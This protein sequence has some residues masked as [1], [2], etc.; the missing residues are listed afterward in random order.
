[1]DLFAKVTRRPSA[2][3][4]AVGYHNDEA[5]LVSVV[6]HVGRLLNG[7]CQ[8]RAARRRQGIHRAHDGL[9]GVRRR[10]EIEMNVAL[11]VGSW[12]ISDEAH[13]T[14][15][16]GARQNLGKRAPRFVNPWDSSARDV[17]LQA[18]STA[19]AMGVSL[20]M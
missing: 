16:C 4:F 2:G 18:R 3:L 5:R 13:A 17:A 12:T 19:K 20:T 9:C 6:K 14:K 15:L 1:M 7:R 8:R 10:L 11:V